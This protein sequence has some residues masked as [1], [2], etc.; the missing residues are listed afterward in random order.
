MEHL[1]T[2]IAECDRKTELAKRRLKETQEELSEEATGKV[3]VINRHVTEQ[4][5]LVE[6]S[7]FARISL[8]MFDFRQVTKSMYLY[9]YVHALF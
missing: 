1:E 7:S 8:Q 3:R 2:F 9:M 6:T 5:L 4:V